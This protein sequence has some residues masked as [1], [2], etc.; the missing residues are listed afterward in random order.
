M[1]SIS[2]KPILQKLAES[3]VLVANRTH[4]IFCTMISGSQPV[5]F[6]WTKNGEKISKSDQYK[7]VIEESFS[8]LTL[9]KLTA[10]DSATYTCLAKN[11]F[12]QDQTSTRLLIKG[13]CIF[14]QN[15]ALQ[16]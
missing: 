6:E 9:K 1:E 14:G 13:I 3:V 5:F 8:A 12:G 10:D 16:S 11:A 2:E 7:L 4:V 15:M